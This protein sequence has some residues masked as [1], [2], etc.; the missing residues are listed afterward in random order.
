[1]NRDVRMIYAFI[2]AV[3]AGFFGFCI[4]RITPKPS[5]T[6]GQSYVTSVVKDPSPSPSAQPAAIGVMLTEKDTLGFSVRAQS[7]LWLRNTVG[8]SVPIPVM[9]MGKV[10]PLFAIF[11]D[12]TS[13]ETAALDIAIGQASQS[14]G[15]L[16]RQHSHGEID[17]TGAKLV[18]EIMPFAEEGG[19][20]YDSLLRQ[21]EAVLGSERFSAFSS[22]FSESFDQSFD[23]YGL[24]RVH[25]E[26]NRNPIAFINKSPIYGYLRTSYT[27]NGNGNRT[28]TGAINLQDI[29]KKHPAL[30]KFFPMLSLP[31]EKTPTTN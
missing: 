30:D 16:A 23:G 7:T 20:V 24:N 12:L 9:T 13:T 2:L 6:T 26:V 25:Y 4:G 10:D 29:E 14:L 22:L 3:A 11:F 1:M 19:A 17:A 21:F 5:I 28:D 15:E 8:I 27:P 31:H 18:V